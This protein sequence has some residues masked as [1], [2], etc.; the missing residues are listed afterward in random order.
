MRNI[1]WSK[2]LFIFTADL[3]LNSILSNIT[4]KGKT[5]LEVEVLK[6]D[7]RP[8]QVKDENGKWRSYFRNKDQ[9][10]EANRVLLHIWRKKEKNTGVLVR[11]GRAEN[12]LM[13][14]LTENGSIT[15]SKFKK[16]ARISP[17]M[18]EN[19]LANLI[20]FK[21]IIMNVSEKG[22]TYELNPVEQEAVMAGR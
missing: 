18:A 9:N 6:G 21:V 16:I 14:Y 20:I 11:F 2:L 3:R 8:Y 13:D 1:I 5:I 17:Y 4:T 19:I 15:M 10:L 12:L 22:F 7:K